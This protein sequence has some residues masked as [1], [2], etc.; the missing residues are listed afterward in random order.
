MLGAR[1][2]NVVRV[3]P[4]ARRR[5]DELFAIW[6]A[7]RAEANLALDAWRARPGREAYLVYRAAED[8]ADAAEIALSAGVA[9]SLAVSKVRE[10][11]A[12]PDADREG[13]GPPP[14]AA[15]SGDR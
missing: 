2:G 11:R 10:R 14:A 5:S 9:G 12:G 8:R 15:G 13:D 6:S 1:R 7:A 4:A 3:F